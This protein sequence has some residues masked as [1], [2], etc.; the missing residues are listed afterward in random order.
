M[1]ATFRGE[2]GLS[3]IKAFM[4]DNVVIKTE[5]GESERVL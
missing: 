2:Q 3:K 5:I 1:T 4:N